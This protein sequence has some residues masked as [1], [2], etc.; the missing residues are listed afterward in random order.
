M[1]TLP[2]LDV[3]YKPGDLCP[4]TGFY[5]FFGY[6]DGTT[7]PSPREDELQISL[8]KGRFFPPIHSTGMDCWWRFVGGLNQ[9]RRHD[10]PPSL[11]PPGPARRWV[12]CS[13]QIVDFEN[14]GSKHA[15]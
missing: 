4:K 14:A 6:L 3:L 10:S 2:D 11:V 5:R 9:C 1:L 7:D 12:T 13:F 15:S 8:D